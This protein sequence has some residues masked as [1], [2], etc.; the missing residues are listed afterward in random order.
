M[1]CTQNLDNHFH[2]SDGGNV[3]YLQNGKSLNLIRHTEIVWKRGSW[4][5]QK[6]IQNLERI[7]SLNFSENDLKT[8][9]VVSM[10]NAQTILHNSKEE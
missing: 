1:G 6:Y 3:F 8:K 5:T 7:K 2:T 10:Q 9:N 4:A